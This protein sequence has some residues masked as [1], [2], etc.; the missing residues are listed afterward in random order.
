MVLRWVGGFAVSLLA[1]G[2]IALGVPRP[3]AAPAAR[4]T[5]RTWTEKDRSG[6]TLIKGEVPL[7][8]SNGKASLVGHHDPQATLKLNFG[9]PLTDRAGLDALI[10]SEARTHQYLSDDELYSRF[11]PPE[12]QT[13][14]LRDW[15]AAQGFR[16]T[17]AGRDRMAFTATATTAQ[18]ERTLHVRIND[19]VRSGY[20]FR[21]SRSSR[22]SSTPTPATRRCRRGSG[23]RRSPA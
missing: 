21:G 2:V 10:A 22:T 14:A 20:D 18:V 1:I 8:L 16:I 11:S 9:Y 13:A 23:C 7:A 17:H 19:Y 12:Q 4:S 3:S 6:S 5:A 15:L